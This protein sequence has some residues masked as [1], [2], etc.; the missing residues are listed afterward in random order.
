MNYLEKLKSPKWQKKRLEILQ[1]DEFKCC[2]CNDTETELQIH[3]LKYTQEPWQ[4]PN[5]DLIT[6]CKHCHS[7]VSKYKSL[8]VIF[9]EKNCYDSHDIISLVV[10]SRENNKEHIVVYDMYKDDIKF[11]VEFIIGGKFHKSIIKLTS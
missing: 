4:A 2:Y 10:K 3:H 9:I 6:L 5:K 8:D 7:L 1:R 11:I